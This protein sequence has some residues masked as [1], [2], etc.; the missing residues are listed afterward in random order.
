MLTHKR[1]F[2]RASDFETLTAVLKEDAP[3]P[4]KHR[5]GIDQELN[6]II[7]TA[8]DKDR[9]HR[10]ATVEVFARELT[11]WYY[12]NVT[13]LEKESL[14]TYMQTLYAQKLP[15]T[16]AGKGK[17]ALSEAQT[18]KGKQEPA[19]KGRAEVG[20]KQRSSPAM[21]AADA[22]S[23]SRTVEASAPEILRAAPPARAR[24][25]TG[26]PPVARP[27]LANSATILD[28][29]AIN[30][31]DL[32]RALAES[33]GHKAGG[34]VAR[35]ESGRTSSAVKPSALRTPPKSGSKLWLVVTLA[36][37]GIGGVVA[38]VLAATGT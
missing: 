36:V 9:E 38:A 2:V 28:D 16:S 23:L 8:L 3:E 27:D 14:T 30:Q 13:D 17:P 26:E 31:A 24:Q 20:N 18:I 15:Q 6:D 1:L 34:A 4:S 33:R 7:M 35:H 37:L 25:R 10:Q 32:A 19:A 5:Q 21:A 12:K 22:K 11:R 29:G